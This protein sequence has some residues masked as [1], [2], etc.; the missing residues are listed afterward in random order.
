MMTELLRFLE[1]RGASSIPH[2]GGTLL[3]HLRRTARRLESWG[4]DD[5]LQ[6]L[7]LAHATFGTDGFGVQLLDVGRR[8]ELAALVGSAVEAQ[9]YLYASCARQVTYPR[10]GDRPVVRFTDRFTGQEREIPAG[11]LRSF[12]ELT[13]ANEL[14]VVLHAADRIPGQAG[15]LL[16]L[17]ERMSDLL[18]PAAWLDGQR[19]LKT[20]IR[21][22]ERP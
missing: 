22:E 21:E 16:S 13:A 10:L 5:D 9:V 12:A 7:A 19:I 6:T 2:P 15:W 8:S 17:L 18:S 14:D 1:A 3:A 4:A 11:E 20:R